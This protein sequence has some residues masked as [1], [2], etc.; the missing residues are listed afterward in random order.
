[1][2]RYPG[3]RGPHGK[4]L[5]FPVAHGCSPSHMEVHVVFSALGTEMG[6]MSSLTFP[7]D[8]IDQEF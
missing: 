1:M 7:I 5:T 3:P 2:K 8:Q 6:R 4:H